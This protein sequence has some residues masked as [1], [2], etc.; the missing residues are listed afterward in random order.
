MKVKDVLV[1]TFIL[2]FDVSHS[3]QSAK[4]SETLLFTSKK[5]CN[6]FIR[7][8]LDLYLCGLFPTGLIS[9]LFFFLLFAFKKNI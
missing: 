3:T 4:E 5:S 1:F 6:N 2:C 7:G 9:L 8:L